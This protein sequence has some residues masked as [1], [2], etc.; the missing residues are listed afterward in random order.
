MNWGALWEIQRPVLRLYDYRIDVLAGKGALF[1]KQLVAVWLGSMHK[2]VV[3]ATCT[4]GEGSSWDL[5]RKFRAKGQISTTVS[6]G[7]GS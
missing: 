6:V 4:F 2:E 3:K 5:R 7:A 1:V